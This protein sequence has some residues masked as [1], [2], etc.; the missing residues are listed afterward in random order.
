M[1][2][3][4]LMIAIVLTVLLL[5]ISCKQKDA[6]R[7]VAGVCKESCETNEFEFKDAVCEQGLK[8]CFLNLKT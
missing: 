6:C 2:I 7:D 5:F 4:F 8:C 1:K 3:V